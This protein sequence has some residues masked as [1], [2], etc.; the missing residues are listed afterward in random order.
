MSDQS[1]P[2]EAEVS[3]LREA[4]GKL[5]SRVEQLEALAGGFPATADPD[6]VG[7]EPVSE[8]SEPESPPVPAEDGDFP[9][10]GEAAARAGANLGAGWIGAIILVLAG[11]F[12]LRALTE[13][14]T[15]SRGLGTMVGLIY[16]FCWAVASP[17]LVGRG[18]R[19]AAT[20]AGIASVLVTLP[21]V[22]EGCVRF[23]SL[24][25]GASAG[26]LLAGGVIWLVCS[27]RHRL[28]LVTAVAVLGIG[29]AS[30]AM[31]IGA[32]SPGPFVGVLAVLAVAAAFAGP[33]R[34]GVSPWLAYVFANLGAL[35][36]LIGALSEKPIVDAGTATGTLIGFGVGTL[37]G[38]IC[39]SRSSGRVGAQAI[40]QGTAA[41]LLG[42][43]GVS[44][45]P[46]VN[47]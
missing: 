43:S 19:R 14:G 30:L 15:L 16:A 11:G 25:P 29:C 21:L 28:S 41:T 7:R 46:W 32:R 45:S 20:A 35:L 18:R 13:S 9:T 3:S 8:P 38:F 31:S 5:E 27:E 4:L 12:L 47:R 40:L 24:T 33:R 2:L 37:G 22:W 10:L 17:L 23:K 6:I 42:L 39:W 26:L 44:G 1:T 34:G 36:L